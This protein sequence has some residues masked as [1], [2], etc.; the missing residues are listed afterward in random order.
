MSG[1]G[2][3]VCK[4]TVC[5]PFMLREAA[6]SNTIGGIKSVSY[7]RHAFSA[8]EVDAL[9]QSALTSGD[10][11]EFLMLCVLFTSGVCTPVTRV[12]GVKFVRVGGLRHLPMPAASSSHVDPG[13][14]FQ[15][16]ITR[17]KGGKAYPV[18]SGS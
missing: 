3:F 10:S 17:E 4:G 8:A 1:R 13:S 2:G 5:N 14:E 16:L 9:Y 15:T 18:Q 6:S 7:S 11:L 12:T